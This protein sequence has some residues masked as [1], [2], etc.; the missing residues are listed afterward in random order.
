MTNVYPG[1]TVVHA[2]AAAMFA[3]YKVPTPQQTSLALEKRAPESDLRLPA[4][5]TLERQYH[6]VLAD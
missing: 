4:T 2:T 6:S 1:G 5:L 3:G